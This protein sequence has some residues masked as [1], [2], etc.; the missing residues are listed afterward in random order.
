MV[1]RLVKEA[2]IT[3][4]VLFI[5]CAVWVIVLRRGTV[6]I[7]IWQ[8]RVRLYHIGEP[9]SF[10]LPCHFERLHR[11]WIQDWLHDFLFCVDKAA[12]ILGDQVSEILK[13]RECLLLMLRRRLFLAG[14]QL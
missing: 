9:V 14:K 3:I 4:G 7:L 8:S 13:P 1:N 10:L 5:Q 2:M 11:N 6:S 12:T